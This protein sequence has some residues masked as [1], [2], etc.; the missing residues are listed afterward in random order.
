MLYIAPT[1]DIEGKLGEKEISRDLEYVLDLLYKNDIKATFNI[2]AITTQ[3]ES[4]ESLRKI[5][6]YNYEIGCHGY[7]HAMNWNRKRIQ[8]QKEI[9]L[10]S[11]TVL[12]NFFNT[13]IYGWATPRGGEHSANK[14]L[15]ANQGFKWVR[16]RSITDYTKNVQIK[17]LGKLY[18][19]PRSGFDESHF[20]KNSRFEKYNYKELWSSSQIK[21]YYSNLLNWSIS[22]RNFF[23]S[24]N[25]PWVISRFKA[26]RDGFTFFINKIK[27]FQETGYLKT[28][29]MTEL[30]NNLS[31]KS[32]SSHG[33]TRITTHFC[34]NKELSSNIIFSSKNLKY[35]ELLRID[36]NKKAV[37]ID[38]TLNASRVKLF[39][40]SIL[41]LM[42]KIKF[43]F[44]IE[45]VKLEI[46]INTF[47]GVVHI[48][49]KIEP[50]IS[51]FLR[52]Y[53][54]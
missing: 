31:N 2:A 18:D 39:L 6:D 52:I 1:F 17:K 47:K 40:F 21:N 12:E 38:E 10:R 30:I 37:Y 8:D 25:H 54:R 19:I 45:I 44:D 27:T 46:K 50:F 24:N 11:K 4:K 13:E 23:V 22:N 14:N 28:L 33:N 5:L 9:I 26:V 51:T 7:R 15:L 34:Y 36:C 42:N 48:K 20:L 16:D 3:F 43:D 53:K 29:K 41:D 35:Y 49:G 32:F